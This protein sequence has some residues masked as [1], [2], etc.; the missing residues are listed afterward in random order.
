M[1]TREQ[2]TSERTRSQATP[3]RVGR[4]VVGQVRAG[5]FSKKVRG[6]AHMLR[7]PAAWAFDRSSLVAAENAGAHTVRVEDTETG[8]LYTVGLPVLWSTGIEIDRGFGQQVAL[9][10]R[11]WSV[12]M[13]SS[14]V[15][16]SQAQQLALAG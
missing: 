4:R 6:S 16:L 12:E 13:R 3:V 1:L 9:P 11:Y 5:V 15:R 2:D 14:S 10:L 7:T 8:V